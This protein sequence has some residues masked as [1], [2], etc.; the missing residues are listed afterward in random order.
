MEELIKM[1][2]TGKYMP[3]EFMV[4][5]RHVPGYDKEAAFHIEN[6]YFDNKGFPITDE[7]GVKETEVRKESKK[8]SYGDP[9][10]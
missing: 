10:G 4:A 7:E 8:V 2:L 6:Q 1:A 5:A 9:D 3:L